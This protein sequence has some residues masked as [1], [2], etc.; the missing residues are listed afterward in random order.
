MSFDITQFERTRRRGRVS[1]LSE[2][3]RKAAN[4]K[5]QRER[6]ATVRLLLERYRKG[7]IELPEGLIEQ[8]MASAPK[9]ERKAK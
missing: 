9:R 1:G 5:A 7:E 3:E 4:E 2:E 6:A 8:E